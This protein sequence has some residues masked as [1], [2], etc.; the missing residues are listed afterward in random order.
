VRRS[1]A[2]RPYTSE[3]KHYSHNKV[4]HASFS[5][6]WKNAR[7][8][9]LYTSGERL[10]KSSAVKIARIM[11]SDAVAN[12]LAMV[13]LW[14]NIIKW[15]IQEISVHILK[16]II[17]A[18]KRSGNLISELGET[19]DLGNDAQFMVFVRYRVTEYYVKQFLF[20]RPLAKHTTG[21]KM[22]KK[23]D[24]FV[25]NIR[26]RGLTACQFVPMEAAPGWEPKKFYE[27]MKKEKNIFR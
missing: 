10:V 6:A 18:A 13:R 20:C 19:T 12:K 4:V 25:K 24:S 21:K 5:V 2:Y 23:V 22:F 9:A 17:A 14:N 11:C 26:H 16:R 7:A 1:R 15:R 8:K 27:F 3:V